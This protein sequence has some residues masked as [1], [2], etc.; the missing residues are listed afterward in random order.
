MNTALTVAAA[1]LRQRLASPM[2][3][4]LTGLALL[5]PLVA[6]AFLRALEPIAG[7]AAYLGLVFA[8]G[9]IGQEVSSGVLQL[10]FARPIRRSE[11]V[12]GRW[13]GAGGGAAAAALAQL[14]AA[15]LIVSARGAVPGAATL[16]AAALAAIVSAFAAAA[17]MI[18]FSAC[19][20]GL[21]DVA[22]YVQALAV[23]WLLKA[24]ASVRS[25]AVMGTIAEELRRT[26][27]PDLTA[28]VLLR[29]GTG[30]LTALVVAFAST[31]VALAIAIALV[32][33]KELSYG[34]D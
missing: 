11:W 12:A 4:A 32:N 19:V 20:N 5:P 3:V 7:T 2:R 22:L 21:G 8:A 27:Q 25:D 16:G 9:A 34:A 1:L 10:A 15:A 28:N 33:R 24:F 29:P 14:A 31:A 18:A 17:V 26:V 30:G 6:V 13:L 23:A